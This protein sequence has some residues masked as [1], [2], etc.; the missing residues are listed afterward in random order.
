MRPRRDVVSVLSRLTTQISRMRSKT[1]RV[2]H[3]RSKSRK[4]LS[5][6]PSLR[7]KRSML[8]HSLRRNKRR[9]R[10]RSSKPSSVP[11]LKKPSHP[12]KARARKRRRRR[13]LRARPSP[14]PPRRPSKRLWLASP[15]SS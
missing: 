15:L 1:R 8:N 14:L 9:R 4:R 2:P 7:R 12:V 6:Y 11:A 5:L 10:W 3:K 13:P